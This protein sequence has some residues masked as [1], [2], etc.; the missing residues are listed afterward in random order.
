MHTFVLHAV[1]KTDKQSFLLYF[2]K[3]II[4]TLVILLTVY[5]SMFGV[6]SRSVLS[7][8]ATPGTTACPA[9]LSMGILQ[10]R[11]LERV[12][13]PSSRGSSQTRDRTQVSH[14]AGRLFTI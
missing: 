10:A 3:V 6:L 12:A 11:I 9:S 7:D 13:I 1:S 14:T 5:V 4:F 8:S 2:L